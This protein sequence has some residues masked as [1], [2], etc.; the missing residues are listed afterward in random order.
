MAP[1]GPRRS[2]DA[3]VW[4]ALAILIQTGVDRWQVTRQSVC[5]DFFTLWAVAGT[6][7]DVRGSIYERST[8]SRMAAVA[9]ARA[10]NTGAEAEQRVMAV[11]DQLYGDRLDTTGSPLAYALVGLASSG[12]YETDLKR[13]A[14][15]SYAAFAVAILLLCRLLGYSLAG[16]ALAFTAFG[17]CFTPLVSDVRVA[18]VNQVQLLALAAFAWL[19]HRGQSVWAGLVLGVSIVFKP[20]TVLVLAV[21]LLVSLIDNRRQFDV[22]LLAGIAGGAAA[23]VAVAALYFG[24]GAIWLQFAAS[25]PATLGRG[26]P[27]THG[28]FSAGALL[29]SSAGAAAPLITGGLA[30]IALTWILWS[31]RAS[32]IRP[33]HESLLIVGS[34]ACLM[35]LSSGLVW[36]HYYVLL[37]PVSLF[38]L[39]PM[40][41]TTGA[42]SSLET[43]A[44]AA[45]LFMFLP[46]LHGMLPTPTHSAVVINLATILLYAVC[47]IIWRRQRT[48]ATE[49]RGR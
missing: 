33:A 4:L 9:R 39:R 19:L 41:G 5:L 35:L 44:A 7:A 20:V 45:S 38:L 26:Y 29:A 27:L 47:L 31:T 46:G 42:V 25:L 21:G 8:Q 6:A 12:N 28:N 43:R 36:V 2:L 30:L 23:G 10:I 40:A 24:T 17:M 15:A 16:T 22:R 3:L 13:F 34:G 1:S 18:N 11:S 49:L 32:T 14:I 37:I 48:T